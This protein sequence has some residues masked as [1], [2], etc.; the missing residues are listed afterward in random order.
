MSTISFNRNNCNRHRAQRSLSFLGNMFMISF[1]IYIG[2]IICGFMFGWMRTSPRVLRVCRRASAAEV[3][4]RSGETFRA[5]ARG[6]GGSGGG[7]SG[8]GGGGALLQGG[9]ERARAAAAA[10]AAG[11]KPGP[12]PGGAGGLRAA[13]SFSVQYVVP[14]RD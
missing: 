5:A 12:G 14:G 8:S 6:G 3:V 9:E 11:T 4:R 13:G 1:C 10:A 7:T 2:T